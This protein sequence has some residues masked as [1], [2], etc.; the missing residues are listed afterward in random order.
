MATAGD[1]SVLPSSSNEL[2]PAPLNL[3]LN[4]DVERLTNVADELQLRSGSQQ[5]SKLHLLLWLGEVR[6]AVSRRRSSPV[7]LFCFVCF[8]LCSFRFRISPYTFS[9]SRSHKAFRTQKL[10]SRGSD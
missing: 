9:R 3:T 8:F 1:R 10:V 5:H 7:R 2:L 6:T 4:D